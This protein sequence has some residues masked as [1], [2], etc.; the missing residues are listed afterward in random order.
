MAS[1]SSSLQITQEEFFAFHNIDRQL[2]SRLVFNLRREPS[3]AMQAAALWLWLEGLN[4]AQYIVTIL[5]YPDTAF[6]ALIEE[7]L[8]CLKAA[9]SEE[10][11]YPDDVPMVQSIVGKHRDGVS[12]RFFHENR[13]N[14]LLGVGNIIQKI[15]IRAFEDLIKFLMMYT[16]V[17]I[18]NHYHEY[19]LESSYTPNVTRGLPNV[20]VIGD[21]GHG[22][23]SV[24]VIG[25]G[26]GIAR[27]GRNVGVIGDGRGGPNVGVIGDGR[28]RA[29][30]LRPVAQPPSSPIYDQNYPS[31]RVGDFS[32]SLKGHLNVSNHSYLQGVSV[33]SSPT[34]NGP[35]PSIK[36]VPSNKNYV[37]EIQPQGLAGDL[38]DQFIAQLRESNNS[39]IP[40]FQEIQNIPPSER[41]VFLT[42]SKGYPISETELREFFNRYF[43]PHS[44]STFSINY[45]LYARVFLKSRRFSCIPLRTPCFNELS[46][47]IFT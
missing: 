13:I 33:V 21:H 47:Y 5:A 24:G 39:R 28:G 38:V 15:C 11:F 4:M 27:G 6:E 7:T 30:G 1:S 2:F 40:M 23:L 42:F 43:F 36:S 37:L 31:L 22:G 3:E 18:I 10:W 35:M 20:G 41:T 8:L 19:P 34:N 45:T 32:V 9:E 12:L 29:T 14:V 16:P 46:N 17:S 25:D 26:R 44:I